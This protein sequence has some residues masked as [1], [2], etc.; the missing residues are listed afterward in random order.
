MKFVVIIDEKCPNKYYAL[1]FFLTA[2]KILIYLTTWKLCVII[3]GSR[4]FNSKAA[5]LDLLILQVFLSFLGSIKQI[6]KI[7][8]MR[9]NKIEQKYHHCSTYSRILNCQKSICKTSRFD[10]SNSTK[11]MLIYRVFWTNNFKKYIEL[12]LKHRSSS[13]RF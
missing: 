10:Y 12:S 8:G 11:L 9:Q 7:T 4:L 13:V 5:S 3:W 1:T 6:F 2:T